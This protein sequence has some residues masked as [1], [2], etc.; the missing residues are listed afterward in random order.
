VQQ[1]IAYDR[2]AFLAERQKPEV[3]IGENMLRVN[4]QDNGLPVYEI[5]I[6]E[7]EIGWHLTYTAKVDGWKP[8]S[9][10]SQFGKLGFFSWVIPFARA[11]VTGMLT[12]GKE[13]ILVSG[14]GYHNH[15]WLNYPFQ[16][17]INY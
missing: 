13:T 9:G 17:I 15:N 8:G 4:Q 5:N 2:S 14:I 11:E 7:K 3:A 1:F 12:D 16:T 6:H 10:L